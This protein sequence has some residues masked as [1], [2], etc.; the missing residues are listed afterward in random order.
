MF[1]VKKDE[2]RRLSGNTKERILEMLL[3]CP[4]SLGGI[5]DKLP[6]QKSAVRV[7]LEMLQS[8]KMW[9]QPFR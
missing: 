3:E 1:D 9:N 4:K 5:T 6:I 7:H 8:Q 2:Q